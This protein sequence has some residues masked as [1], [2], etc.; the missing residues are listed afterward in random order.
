MNEINTSTTL[1]ENEEAFIYKDIS[2]KNLKRNLKT[3]VTPMTLVTFSIFTSSNR[4]EVLKTG[5]AV[6][7]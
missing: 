4:A 3:D 1:E 7:K 6:Y 5:L 2:I